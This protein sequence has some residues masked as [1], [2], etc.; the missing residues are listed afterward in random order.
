MTNRPYFMWNDRRDKTRLKIY[1]LGNLF[2]KE[3]SHSWDLDL[4]SWDSW[5]RHPCLAF[6]KSHIYNTSS[7]QRDLIQGVHPVLFFALFLCSYF[8]SR[9]YST[10]WSFKCLEETLT[11][12]ILYLSPPP[13]PQQHLKDY[14]HS[15]EELSWWTTMY[16]RPLASR[17][18]YF[19]YVHEMDHAA[20]VPRRIVLLYTPPNRFYLLSSSRFLHDSYCL[21]YSFTLEMLFFKVY[22]ISCEACHFPSKMF[23]SYNLIQFP[24]C[25]V[26]EVTLG[27]LY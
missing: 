3:V 14:P 17:I 20:D 15:T 26:N 27:V 8:A 21:I 18:L 4:I 10:K 13:P 2:S 16:L 6:I 22:Y 24:F 19:F 11:S 25:S 9:E 23:L 12:L 7:S 5:S 1:H